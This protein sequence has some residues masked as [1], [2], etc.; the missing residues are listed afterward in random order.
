MEGYRDFIKTNSEFDEK[1]WLQNHNSEENKI[2]Q[3]SCIILNK[4]YP[5]WYPSLGVFK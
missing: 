2:M 4:E 1:K 3:S 5:I